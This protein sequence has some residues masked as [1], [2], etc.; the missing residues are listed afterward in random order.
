MDIFVEHLVK[1]KRTGKDF[2]KILA[3]LVGVLIILMFLPVVLMIK[4]VGPIAFTA[5]IGLIYLLYRLIT[6]TNLEYEYCFTNGALDVDKVI[7][8]RSRK[9]LLEVNARKIDMMASNKN[10]EFKRYLDDSTTKKVYAC[11]HIDDEGVYFVIFP[12]KDGRTMLL[13]NPNDKIK[14]G[15]RRYNPQKVTLDD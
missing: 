14:E 7:N 10:R 9:R 1:K 8:M 6:A 15:F 4:L 5:C 13:F 11:T 3:C 12:G 2:V